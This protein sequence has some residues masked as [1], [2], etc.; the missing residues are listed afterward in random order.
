[1]W[2]CL[3]RYRGMN[4]VSTVAPGFFSRHLP[5][6]APR[7]LVV[8]ARAAENFLRHDMSTYAAALAYRGLFALFPFL[9]FLIALINAL[10]VWRLF[11][12]LGDWAQAAPSGRLPN[13]IR[14]W[15]VMQVHGGADGAAITLAI[16]AAVWVVA[17]GAR[18]L[19]RALNAVAE[20]D[21]IEPG[22]QRLAWSLMAAPVLGTAA[23]AGV[24]LFTLTSRALGEAAQWFEIN[25]TLVGVWNWIRFPAGLSLAV[26]AASAIYRFAPSRPQPLQ[27]VWPGAAVAAVAWTGASLV[28]AH[29]ILGAMRLGVTYGSFSAGIVLLV[30]LYLAAAAVLFGAELNAAHRDL[31]N[32]A[33]KDERSQIGDDRGG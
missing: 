14:Q 6:A 18:V 19:R 17:T 20:T 5:A 28:F 12:M 11:A 16:T 3:Y 1:M 32:I 26:V 27:S 30:Y 25:H 8:L 10:D 24:V 21:D 15:I 13:A 4:E 33:H 31:A 22:W 7:W 2:P 9:I 29:A 23:L